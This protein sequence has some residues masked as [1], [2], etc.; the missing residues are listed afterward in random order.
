MQRILRIFGVAFWL[1]AALTAAAGA[2][3]IPS[4]K[5]AADHRTCIA[6]CT[7]KGVAVARC[8]QYCDCTFKEIGR[9]FTLEE[10]NAAIAAS[11]QNQQ[12]S[13]D[14]MDRMVKLTKAC[15]AQMK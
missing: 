10:Y 1:T 7:Q 11:Q 5:L 14:V 15:M 6:A 8:T 13:Q 12:P 2:E 3:P 9:Q 4:D